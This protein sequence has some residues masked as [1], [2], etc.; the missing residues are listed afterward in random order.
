MKKI[1][2]L[3]PTDLQSI[4]LYQYQE[5]LNTFENPENMTDEEASLKM[6]EIFCGVKQKEGLKFKMSDVSLVVD[7]LN[8]ILVSK[9]SLITKFT[10]GGQKFGFVPELSELSF[11]E[12]IDAENN[13]GDWNNMHKAMAVLYRPIKEEYKDK[14]T[15]K[16]YDGDYYSEILKNMPTSVAISCLVFFYALETELLNHTLNSSLKTLKIKTQPLEQKRISE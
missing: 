14:Y 15:L 13:L 9:P 10:L 4:P 16:E 7:K 1:E 11:G 6:L 2:L 5:F 8:K 3:V 12:Y